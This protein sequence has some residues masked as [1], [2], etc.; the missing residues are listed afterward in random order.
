MIRPAQHT[1]TVT[2]TCW[3]TPATLKL[4]FELDG[5]PITFHP[6]QYV[7]VILDADPERE[8]RKELRPYSLWNHPAEGGT[9]STIVRM[10]EGG[11]ASTLYTH[12]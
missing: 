11:R 4:D 12:R 5:D 1:A 3:L 10:V 9:L 6:G 7:S 2:G 8:L